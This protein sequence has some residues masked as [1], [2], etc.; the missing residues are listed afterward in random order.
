MIITHIGKYFHPE[1]G[2]IETVTQLLSQIKS[3]SIKQINI[4]C[5]S[6]SN[7]SKTKVSSSQ[8][9]YRYKSFALFSQ[10]ISFTYFFSGLFLLNRSDIIHLHYPNII[11]QMLCFFTN[12]PVIVHWHSDIIGKNVLNFIISPLHHL[13]LSKSKLI[14]C[15][16]MEY[17]LG[18]KILRNYHKKIKIIPLGISDPIA[19][20]NVQSDF[21]IEKNY[22]LS[23]GR[24]VPYKGFFDLVKAFQLLKSKHKLYIVGNGPQYKQLL[25][26]ITELNLNHRIFILTNI[27]DNDLKQLYFH[28]DCYCLSSNTRA[29]AFGVVL[30]EALAWSLPIVSTRILHSGVSWVNMN[31]VTGLKVPTSCPTKLANALDQILSDK[32]LQK[33]FGLNS[34]QRYEELFSDK[35][36]QHSF[37][38]LYKSMYP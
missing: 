36:F 27:S 18:S 37:L 17:F 25:Q 8:C 7:N 23:V 4:L 1:K 33:V 24:L 30:L 31:N 38:S 29:E 22:V 12:R 5:F 28:A 13:L 3:N 35:K 11:G 14:I 10:P 6:K 20:N 21:I 26:L 32:S 15:T 9:I 16:S 19:N 34:R 2:G